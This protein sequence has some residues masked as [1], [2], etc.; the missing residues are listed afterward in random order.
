MK[1]ISLLCVLMIMVIPGCTSLHNDYVVVIEKTK[2]Y[3]T[4]HCSKVSMARTTTM[5]QSEALA[6]NFKPCPGCKPSKGL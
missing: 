1:T 2:T 3:H 4:D 6:L 5:T